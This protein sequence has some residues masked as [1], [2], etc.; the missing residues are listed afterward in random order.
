MVKKI[1]FGKAV[2]KICFV[3]TVANVKRVCK[4]LP[5]RPRNCGNR[6]RTLPKRPSKMANLVKAKVV[7][8]VKE[9]ILAVWMDEVLEFQSE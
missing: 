8:S 6:K 9:W 3:N 5:P 1:R 2:N 4:K 7:W